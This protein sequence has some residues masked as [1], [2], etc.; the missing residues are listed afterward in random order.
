MATNLN[1]PQAE[2]NERP[3]N[4]ATIPS[5]A[6][7]R[8]AAEEIRQSWT[9]RQRRLRAQV[10]QYILWSQLLP[11]GDAASDRGTLTLGK[12]VSPPRLKPKF[13]PGR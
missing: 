4:P 2:P 8:S 7:V 9:P 3:D 6:L 1:R 10:A 5:P 13:P 12:H 11:Q